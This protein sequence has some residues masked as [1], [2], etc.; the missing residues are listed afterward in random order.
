MSHL[1]AAFTGVVFQQGPQV[2]TLVG[3]VS[4]HSGNRRKE[5]EKPLQRTLSDDVKMQSQMTELAVFYVQLGNQK[6]PRWRPIRALKCKIVE[7]LP[8]GNRRK[9]DEAQCKHFKH[10]IHNLPYTKLPQT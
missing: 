10:I 3:A 8:F 2:T 6:S 4:K 1:F 5:W 9:S 7:D